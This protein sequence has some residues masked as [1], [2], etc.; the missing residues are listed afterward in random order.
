MAKP[1]TFFSLYLNEMNKTR[2]REHSVRSL[3]KKY[4]PYMI[5]P[6][7]YQFYYRLDTQ[8][9]NPNHF[10]CL[11]L[12]QK[13]RHIWLSKWYIFTILVLTSGDNFE[14]G[15]SLSFHL[16]GRSHSHFRNL[17]LLSLFGPGINILANFS[18]NFT[19]L[20]FFKTG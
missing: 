3:K 18:R 13:N 12:R 16:L 17:G 11:N 10:R 7:L 1:Q 6:P 8:S 20:Q 4:S 5:L 14:L 9:N 2:L 19:S 15:L